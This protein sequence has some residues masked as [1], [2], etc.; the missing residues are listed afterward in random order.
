MSNPLVAP[1]QSQTTAVTG[2]GIAES[3]VDLANGVKDGSW[4]EFGMGA[5]GVGMEVLSMVIDPIGTLAQYGASWLIEHVKPLKDAL[6]W[7]AGNPPVIQSFADTWGNVAKEVGT[8][9]G[10]LSNEA[11]NG[12]AGWTGEGADAYRGH[13]AE[14]ADA[15]AGAAGL[16]DGIS[17]GVMIM[18]QVVAMVRETVRDLVAELVGKLVSWVLEE[19]C[20][21]GFATPLVAAQA[22]TAITN[23]ISK[24]SDTIRKLVKTIGNVSPKIRKII[25]KLGEIL[26]KLRN[27]GRKIGRRA[28]GATT[29]AHAGSHVDGPHLKGDAP[30]TPS[31][32]HTP[33][34]TAPSAAHSS[35]EAKAPDG[36]SGTRVPD[37][38]DGGIDAA[39]GGS[40][41]RTG[42]GSGGSDGSLRGDAKNPRDRAQT[43]EGRCEGREPVDLASGEMYLTQVDVELPGVL[44]LVIGRVHVSS[45]RSGRLFGPSW[46][47]TLDQRLEVDEQGVCFA[48]PDGVI[49]VYPPPR[50]GTEV[51][52]EEGARWPLALAEDGGY[53]ITQ[54]LLGRVLHFA[55]RRAGTAPI[56]A[57]VDRHGNRIDFDYGSDGSLSEIRHTSGYRIDVETDRGL[58]TEL[59][60]R[61]R[62]G[63]AIA[64]TRYGYDTTRGFTEVINSSGLAM[65]FD[66][67]PAGRITKWTDRNGEW[68]GYSYDSAGRCVRTD[69]SGNVFAGTIE[70]DFDE[71]VTRETDSLG[72]VTLHCFNESRQLVRRVDALGNETR[73]RW[74]RYD[75]LLATTD[76]LGRTTTFERD[77]DG[78]VI[79]VN[80]PDGSRLLAD[81]NAIG[82][83]VRQIDPD[84]AVW[85]R[86]Y[87]ARGNLISVTDPTNAVTRYSYYE[88]GGLASVTDAVGNVQRLTVDAT[89]LIIS[90]TSPG[91][92]TTRYSRD[93][94]G[95][96]HQIMD[97]AGGVTVLTW[98]VEGKPLF[99]K[100]PDG[101]VERW[102]YDGEG[103]EL[104]HIDATGRVTRTETTHFDLPA[105]RTTPDGAQVLFAY[106]SE[107]RLVSVTDPRGL[108]WRYEYD[109]V[110][111]LV[112]ETDYDGR[113]VTYLRDAAGQLAERIDGNG[114]R[115]VHARDALG[116]VV[117]STSAAGVCRF[118][119]DPVGRVVAARNATAETLFE[120]DP[121]GR[122][123][124][125][126]TN[127][128][129]VV[130]SYDA[131]GRRT[132]RRTPTGAESHWEYDGNHRPTAL[133]SGGRV[134]SFGYDVTGREVERLVDTGTILAQSW[135]QNHRLVSQTL[136]TVARGPQARRLQQRRYR[137]HPDGHVLAVED[138]TSG[139]RWLDLD[140]VGRP[141]AVRGDR[142]TERYSY[143]LAGNVVAATVPGADPDV[144]GEREYAGTLLSRAGRTSYRYDS[145]GRVVARQ[146]R[147]L[148][149]KPDT[150]QFTWDAEDRLTGVTTPDGSR[151][152]YSY[153][154]LGRRISKQRLGPA[155]STAE[156]TDFV[157]DG[158]VLAEQIHATGR[159]TTW[160][161]EPDGF[162][163][164]VQRERIPAA[165]APQ[166]WIDRQFYSIV[167]DVVGAPT[168][169]VTP[170]GHLAW[171]ADRS[172]WGESSDLVTPLR[173]PGQYFDPET[174]LHYNY[175]RYYDPENARYTSDDPL[176]L[177][178][179]PNPRTYV[180]NP[181][182]YVDPLGLT[183]APGGAHGPGTGSHTNPPPPQ[184]S[185]PISMD[186][187]V[188]LGSRHVGGAG[189]VVRGGSGGYMFISDA[190]DAAGQRVTSI[191]RFDIN[192]NSGHVQSLGPHLNLET[193]VN[194]TRVTSGPYADPH[195]GIDPSTIRPGDIPPVP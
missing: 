75:R 98:T 114:E 38:G 171:Q 81:Y 121:L 62:D 115:I 175:Q 140:P 20:T 35:P 153:D 72:N 168:E 32:A 65:R 60:L 89:G 95:R 103:N 117:E 192:S 177:L 77:E 105:R 79:A 135:D 132:S 39:S 24:V 9:A 14:Q 55:R 163:A 166:E 133:H 145:R 57:I 122:V 58:V 134:I 13:V 194:G 125:E 74:D 184:I 118:E 142:R 25:D 34:G 23:T 139:V 101:S 11:K 131:V 40:T 164:L 158:T 185:G 120:R 172:L 68:Y 33:D 156:R 2:I 152:R 15:I 3:A 147:R 49:L 51:L 59:R 167:T 150:W 189:R 144:Q 112:R 94:F 85:A 126:T 6:D 7:L 12:T 104:E 45:Y 18:G 141:L 170:D 86:E 69:G 97:P 183:P 124:A 19:A 138:D 127:G 191:A 16:A 119:Y 88:N 10:D 123:V 110:G 28:D 47:S 151:W 195:I 93:Q 70:Y 128:R 108:V 64:L 96:I 27:L 190:T 53:T 56:S 41:G 83:P 188:D 154:A 63:A 159:A 66:Y 181:T 67:D 106:D 82:L 129:T 169:L 90:A 61:D 149:R 99:R 92:A 130:S 143:D 71:R 46:A 165:E 54:P 22:T 179:A 178:P 160:D 161:H 102:R 80:R 84:G 21:L 29:P 148:S 100:H 91:D 87:D 43:P 42:R 73:F 36:T 31:H 109:A 146:R 180:P 173:F 5:L 44:P 37:T 176:G 48:D 26:E 155:G 187:A 193:Q 157:W 111:N 107:L 186:E 116:Q 30:T 182:R 136:S 113:A 76:P 174:G 162:R 78:H 1:A 137:Y 17:T 8:I 52:P 50:P 4:V